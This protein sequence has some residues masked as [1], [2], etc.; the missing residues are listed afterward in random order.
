[1][2]RQ[3]RRI[4]VQ[5]DHQHYC[6]ADKHDEHDHARP[7]W[8]ILISLVRLLGRALGLPVLLVVVEIAFELRGDRIRYGRAQVIQHAAGWR[9]LHG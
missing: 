9:I 1:M 7:H 3:S 6:E 5:A 4:P 8:P 2:C